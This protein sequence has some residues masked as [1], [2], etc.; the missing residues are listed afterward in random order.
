MLDVENSDWIG[1]AFCVVTAS[2]PEYESGSRGAYVVF[3]CRAPG[4]SDVVRL[5][6]TELEESGLE[7]R[8]FEFLLDARYIDRPL[9]DYEQMLR[10]R[11][12]PYPVQFENVHFFKPDS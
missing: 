9:S 8:G 7:V 4:L 6:S 5:I 12:D 3:A 11:L 1:K 2:R 10:S